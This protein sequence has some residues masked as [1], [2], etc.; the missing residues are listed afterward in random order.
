MNLALDFHR[1]VEEYGGG[2]LATWS[3]SSVLRLISSL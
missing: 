1:I 3:V 2:V